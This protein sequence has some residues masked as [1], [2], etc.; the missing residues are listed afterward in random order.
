M[1][2]ISLYGYM[3]KGRPYQKHVLTMANSLELMLNLILEAV[4]V[5]PPI[6]LGGKITEM[7][8]NAHLFAGKYEGDFDQLI[9]HL[10]HFN[11][12]FNFTR[13]GSVIQ[14]E[15]DFFLELDGIYR[16]FDKERQREIE[17][18]FGEGMAALSSI[19]DGIK[20]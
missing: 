5:T 1:N 18:E 2:D 20:I 15:D 19:W 9:E 7:D 16:R 4:G 10:R 8:R 3:K 6:N 12:I 14:A 13:N 11:L 17:S